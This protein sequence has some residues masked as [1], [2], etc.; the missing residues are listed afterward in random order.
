MPDI[1]SLDEITEYFTK[2]WA[3]EVCRLL[4][5]GASAIEAF[6]EKMLQ[7]TD[8]LPVY[9]VSKQVGSRTVSCILVHVRIN[10]IIFTFYTFSL[11]FC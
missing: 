6:L 1:I 9:E 11:E 7:E 2:T 4:R 5:P 10:P 3:P 8:D